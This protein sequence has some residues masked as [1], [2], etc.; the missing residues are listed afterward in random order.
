MLTKD[1]ITRLC[2]A[3][4]RLRDVGSTE[5]SIDD[6]AKAAAMSRY[7]FVRQFKAVFG[8]TP[9]GFRTRMRL[10]E[11]KRLLVGSDQSI[12]QICMTVGFSSLGSFSFLFSR[13]F[14]RSPSAYR[15]QLKDSGEDL[16]PGCMDLMRGALT[17][18]S[19]ISRSIASPE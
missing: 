10:D 7:H 17:K 6:V 3:R 5:S 18:K 12:T 11:A 4:D 13:R 8:E 19:Q 9:V 1:H 2:R 15:Q 14:G 16:S